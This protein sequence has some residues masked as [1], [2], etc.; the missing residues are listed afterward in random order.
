[1]RGIGEA[2]K[3]EGRKAGM[4]LMDRRFGVKMPYLDHRRRNSEEESR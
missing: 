2:G 3:G 4:I 1:V